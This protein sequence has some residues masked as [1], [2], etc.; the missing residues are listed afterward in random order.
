[1]GKFAP[2][3]ALD[4]HLDYV[5]ACDELVVCN[6]EPATYA[7]ATSTFALGDYALSGGDFTKDNNPGE[8]GGRRLTVAS[9]SG[10]NADANGTGT[11]IALVRSVDS[12]LRHVT[13]CDDVPM[14][15]GVAF[16]T[17]PLVII[18]RDPI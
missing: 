5:A 6:A 2:D 18:K 9:K 7:Q 10:N 13:T 1:M 16:N 11:H 3:A 12:S 15:S 14:S 8:G 17:G 4:A